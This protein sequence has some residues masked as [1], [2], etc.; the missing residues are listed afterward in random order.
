[1]TRPLAYFINGGAGRVIASIPAF[2]K[3]A[4]TNNDFIIVCE[5]G[6]EIF[7][8]HPILDR[9][10]YDH[11]HKGIFED[12]LK[13]RDLITPEPYRVWE[14]YNQKCSLAQAFDIAIN[15]K[16]IRKLSAPTLNLN[17]IEIAEAYKLV[18]EVKA[19][20]GFEKIVV[21][22]PFGRSVMATHGMIVDPSSRSFAQTDLIEIVNSLKKEYGII[23][24]SEFGNI[25]GIDV[26]APKIPNLRIWAA[27]IEMADYFLGCD[28]VGQHIARAL[29]KISTVVI[30]ST[31]PINVTYPDYSN[32]TIIDIGEGRRVYSP[33]RIS[34]EDTIERI[35]DQCMEM[36]DEHKRQIIKSIKNK[37][38]KSV[39]S[40]VKLPENNMQQ[41]P[42]QHDHSHDHS[43]DHANQTDNNFK[44]TPVAS[45]ISKMS[46]SPIS[47]SNN[48]QIIS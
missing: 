15:N 5:G 12:H 39:K 3:L 22:Q 25:S 14:Y 30:G 16:G 43:H 23:I 18:Q 4:E 34:Q 10:A 40:T 24:M 19:R 2:E 37:L 9:K 47:S 17:K 11:W 38:G 1:M 32:F 21:I 20:S 48:F 8:G 28:S 46:N 7:R 13:H 41:Q 27:V 45:N 35:N 26:A 31:F 36:T 6:S 42:M 44:L 29:E 33:I